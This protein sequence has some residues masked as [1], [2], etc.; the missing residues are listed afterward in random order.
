M[1]DKMRFEARAPDEELV[2]NGKRIVFRDLAKE[3]ILEAVQYGTLKKPLLKLDQ[4]ET[5]AESEE[6]AVFRIGTQYYLF[7]QEIQKIVKLNTWPFPEPTQPSGTPVEVPKELCGTWKATSSNW[8]SDRLISRKS[9]YTFFPDGRCSE[10]M[11]GFGDVTET[12]F[13][14]EQDGSTYLVKIVLDDDVYILRV[15][16][17]TESTLRIV[18]DTGWFEYTKIS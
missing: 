13:D 7:D 9:Q 12:K 14:I 18:D 10:L 16:S 1:Y 17:L 3:M 5:V 8:A 4:S 15:V 11:F 2:F 6:T